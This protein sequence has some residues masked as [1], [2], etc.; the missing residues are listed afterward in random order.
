MLSRALKTLL[1]SG[2]LA[3]SAQFSPA[4]AAL[5]QTIECSS[6]LITNCSGSITVNATSG[7]KDNVTDFSLNYMIGSTAVSIDETALS[8]FSYTIDPVGWFFLLNTVLEFSNTTND[9]LSTWDINEANMTPAPPT[10][11]YSNG[12][13]FLSVLF[14]PA[15]GGGGFDTNVSFAFIP[16]H[17]IPE[18]ATLAIFGL[19]LAGLGIARRRKQV[20]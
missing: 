6:T 19:G 12:N 3:L 16:L 7:N 20:A 9:I 18:P 4:N 15:V 13:S 10:G 5:M 1:I 8:L 2:T 11:T 14:P 17:E